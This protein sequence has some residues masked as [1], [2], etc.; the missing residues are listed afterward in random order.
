M[1]MAERGG[2]HVVGQATR[3]A[4]REWKTSRIRNLD[5]LSEIGIFE[6]ERQSSHLHCAVPV[7]I[8]ERLISL[9]IDN[10]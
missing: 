2:S 6:S 4:G 7:N 3:E 5:R 8:S 1:A 10:K 9:R